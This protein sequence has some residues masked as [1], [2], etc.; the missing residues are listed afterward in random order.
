M[1]KNVEAKGNVV[2]PEGS[3]LV[4]A[5]TGAAAGLP[6]VAVS[7]ESIT[8]NG[9]SVRLSGIALGADQGRG[10][11]VASSGGAGGGEP[12]RSGA[13]STGARVASRLLG[14]DG[15]AGDLI[16]GSVRAGEQTAQLATSP[17][18]AT[19][20]PAPKGTRF[21]VFVASFGSSQ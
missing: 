17:R 14:A 21:F 4:C 3:T 1:T 19:L 18:V 10:I 12:A 2:I 16:D 15:I 20:E 7:C 13:I 5:A 6:R 8:I 11:P 9:Q